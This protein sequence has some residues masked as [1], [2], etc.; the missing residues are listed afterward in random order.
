MRN[1]YCIAHTYRM[2]HTFELVRMGLF[3]R[4][5]HKKRFYLSLFLL[6][7]DRHQLMELGCRYKGHGRNNYTVTLKPNSTGFIAEMLLKLLV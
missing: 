7:L 1:N 4:R 5:C 6:S 3:Y 2:S